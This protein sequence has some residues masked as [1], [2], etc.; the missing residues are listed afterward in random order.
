MGAEDA[1]IRSVLKF[2]FYT[3]KPEIY[4]YCSKNN[5][6][7]IINVVAKTLFNG[8][9]RLAQQEGKDEVEIEYDL[10]V[11]DEDTLD[12]VNDYFVTE[13]NRKVFSSGLSNVLKTEDAFPYQGEVKIEYYSY[14]KSNLDDTVKEDEKDVV[15]FEVDETKEEEVETTEDLYNLYDNSASTF[16]ATLT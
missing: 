6:I 7:E 2:L 3:Y 12:T 1:F 10:T 5:C 8:N 11:F 16:T 13:E 15:L 9:R 14:D 4:E